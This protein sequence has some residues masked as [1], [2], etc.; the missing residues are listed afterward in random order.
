[1]LYYVNHNINLMKSD[2]DKLKCIIIDDDPLMTDLVLHYS[3]KCEDIDYCV[4]CNDSI[5]GLKLLGGGT[6]DILFLDYNMPT[7]DGKGLLGLKQDESKVIMITSEKDFAVES[8]QY[9]DIVDYLMK[10]I[11]Y[12]AF[13]GSINRYIDRNVDNLHKDI[14]QQNFEE[15]L[16]IKDGNK[17]IP[18]LF[19]DILYVKSESNYCTIFTR[20]KSVMTLINLKSLLAKFPNYFIQTHRSFIINTKHIDFLTTEEVSIANKL[21]PISTKYK[22][23]VK[24]FINAFK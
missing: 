8:Y 18:I 3:D 1:M 11:S 10:P 19:K 9:D 12:E 17:W 24:S 21:I 13:V 16:M 20:H 2:N 22:T 15:H 6:F 4:A 5:E 23:T 7:L 14:P